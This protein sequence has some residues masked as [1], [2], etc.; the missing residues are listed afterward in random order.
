[1]N[2]DRVNGSAFEVN[3]DVV[4]AYQENPNHTFDTVQLSYVDAN[5]TNLRSRS[6]NE[7]R[8]KARGLANSFE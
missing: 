4:S 5:D 3:K 6:L 8:M 7:G 1:M 2:S